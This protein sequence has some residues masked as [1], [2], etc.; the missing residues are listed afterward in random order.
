MKEPIDYTILQCPITKEDLLIADMPLL[1]L[2]NSITGKENLFTEGLVNSSKT[3]FFPIKHQI[4]FLLHYYAIPLKENDEQQ[5]KQTFDKQRVFNYYNEISYYE[6]EGQQIYGDAGKFVDFR[7][8]ALNYTQHGFSNTRQ[9][10]NQN[11]N[12]FVDAAS[13]P[14]AFKEYVSLA[15]GFKCRICIDLSVNALLQ[16]QKNLANYSQPGIFICADI[17]GIPLKENI[18]DAVICQHALFHVEKKLQSGALREL[19]R[20]AKPGSK[21]AIVY[22]W[23]YHSLLMNITLGPFQ[24]YR[25]IR[26]YAG[27]LYAK[28]LKKNKLYFYS[29]SP[30]WFYKNNPGI[31]IKIY[32]WRSINKHFADI[33]IH[34]K[35]GGKKL[36]NYIWQLEKKYPEKMGLIGEYPVIVIEK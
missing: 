26:H 25:I 22:D 28:L 6:F 23:F 19:L 7:P 15:N 17:T 33:Y 24:V 10:I 8:F 16:A 30:Q 29:H 1:Q 36:I 31:D 34:E 18:A 35:L 32:T 4:I 5:K 14:V 3:Y 20:I 12:Y 9:Y 27:K 13:G 11:G 21:T 2:A